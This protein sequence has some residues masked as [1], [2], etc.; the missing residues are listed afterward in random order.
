MLGTLPLV[1]LLKWAVII[2]GLSAIAFYFSYLHASNRKT[3]AQSKGINS[4]A[5]HINNA[6]FRSAC[7][8]LAATGIMLMAYII[9]T[10]MRMLRKNSALYELTQELADLHEIHDATLLQLE[11]TER[12]HLALANSDASLDML[13]EK[14][15]TLFI[16]HYILRKCGLQGQKEYSR[17]NAVY[18]NEVKK[19]SLPPNFKKNLLLAAKGSYEEL[20]ADIACD[21]ASTHQLLG[22]MNDFLENQPR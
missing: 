13:K 8:F 11:S 22:Q 10:D 16:N 1:L 6:Y 19:L 21:N 14:Y 4:L 7:L 3:I 17:L 15:E 18:L 2:I 9:H 20:Y 5:N 12:S